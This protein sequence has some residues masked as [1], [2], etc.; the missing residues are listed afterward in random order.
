VQLVY[1]Y[2]YATASTTNISSAL[3]YK[4]AQI[5]FFN[6]GAHDIAPMGSYVIESTAVPPT[7][8][9]QLPN[10][11][12]AYPSIFSE[13][14]M[15]MTPP[16]QQE[17][18]K[19]QSKKM[20]LKIMP[21][22]HRDFC[23]VQIEKIRKPFPPSPGLCILRGAPSVPHLPARHAVDPSTSHCARGPPQPVTH[24]PRPYPGPTRQASEI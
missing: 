14:T 6:L 12:L 1:L 19:S 11:C 8:A 10:L 4:C 5:V 3:I 2:M 22:I 24:H 18:E 20:A 23:L 9:S 17:Q 15:D 16:K 13:H 21:D 7:A